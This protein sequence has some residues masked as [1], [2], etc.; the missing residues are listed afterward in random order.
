MM[1]RVVG[2][3]VFGLVGAVSGCHDGVPGERPPAPAAPAAAPGAAGLA[4]VMRRVHFGFRPDG[5][6][7]AGGHA[8]YGARITAGALHVTPLDVARHGAD[9]VATT[10]AVVRGEARLDA[11]PA[12]PALEPDATL[13]SPAAASSST[14]RTPTTAWSKPGASPSSPGAAAIPWSPSRSPAR[15]TAARRRGACTSSIPRAASAC[16]MAR[17]PGST[18]AARAPRWR[19]RSTPARL[20]SPCPRRWWRGARTPRCSTPRCRP[21][22]GRTTR[23]RSRRPAI[24]P[25]RRWHTGA[26]TTSRC[27]RT[28]GSMRPTRTSGPHGLTRPRARC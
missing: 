3:V 12:A 20:C 1:K 6:A 28:C 14:W 7:W 11:P 18:R 13:P 17:P 26:A 16:V 10:S 22:T 15:S 23:S 2:G 24:R 25:C 5:D 27:G 19:R 4:A 8:T 9:F 21:S